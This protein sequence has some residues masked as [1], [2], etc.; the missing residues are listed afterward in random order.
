MYFSGSSLKRHTKGSEKE[1]AA[2]EKK[3]LRSRERGREEEEEE[4][5]ILSLSFSSPS[6]RRLSA[7]RIL[8]NSQTRGLN[9]L[10]S[11]PLPPLSLLSF[12]SMHRFFLALI[13]SSAS[14]LFLLH[15]L[16]LL[17]P[18]S[19]LCSPPFRH[20]SC[21]ILQPL[22]FRLLSPCCFFHPLAR[23]TPSFQSPFYSSGLFTRCSV[24]LRLQ[25]R[26]RPRVFDY[27][28]C[29][30]LLGIFSPVPV[31]PSV[32]A[33]KRGSQSAECQCREHAR[34]M[35]DSVLLLLFF[36]LYYFF[37]L[38]FVLY[39]IVSFLSFVLSSLSIFRSIFSR[40]LFSLFFSLLLHSLPS[41]LSPVRWSE[42]CR[43]RYRTGREN[44]ARSGDASKT[45]NRGISC[46]RCT[47]NTHWARTR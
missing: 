47:V 12:L 29:V 24:R 39:L 34:R 22:V 8:R 37:F 17:W 19:F 41:L 13:P 28:S 40:L 11:F 32:A 4:G 23:E 43:L 33:P 44:I 38:R 27:L 31:Y 16:L 45:E 18:H 7:A 35:M 21:S 15:P 14:F 1:C 6:C 36:P 9:L 5:S 26:V 2:E 20:R 46:I 25:S 30:L 10:L 42:T 3:S